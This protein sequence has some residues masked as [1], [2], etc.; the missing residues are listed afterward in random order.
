LLKDALRLIVAGA[1]GVLSILAT[2]LALA[3]HKSSA[4]MSNGTLV[5]LLLTPVAVGLIVAVV[6]YRLLEF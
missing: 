2:Y 6:V 4:V 3:L 1:I 5:A